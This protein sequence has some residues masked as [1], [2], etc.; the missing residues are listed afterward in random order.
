MPPLCS[1]LCGPH[2]YP[3][4]SCRWRLCFAS[5]IAYSFALFFFVRWG[6]FFD[7]RLALLSCMEGSERCFC[8]RFEG[9]G[10]LIPFERRHGRILLLALRSFRSRRR[11]S[12]SATRSR[13]LRRS[14]AARRRRICRMYSRDP[15]FES[16]KRRRRR[17]VWASFSSFVRILRPL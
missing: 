17:F 11:F 2:Q 14:F 8:C 13:C 4:L 9:Y 12:T 3:S 5:S 10:S 16:G 1:S 7:C 6:A 15:M